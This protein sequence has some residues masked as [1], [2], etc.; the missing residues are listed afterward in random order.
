MLHETRQ[1]FRSKDFER[2]YVV[3][4][5]AF[6]QKSHARVAISTY[7]IDCFGYGADEAA[8]G[9]TRGNACRSPMA[10]HKAVPSVVPPKHAPMEYAAARSELRAR[11]RDSVPRRCHML[12]A[13]SANGTTFPE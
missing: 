3:S 10:E 6:N 4:I 2:F 12:A 9:A 7:D 1:D 5:I 13:Y 11:G 8:Q